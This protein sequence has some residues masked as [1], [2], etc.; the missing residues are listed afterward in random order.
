MSSA[1]V[2]VAGTE[3]AR[4][5]AA[6]GVEVRTLHGMPELEE[7][8]AVLTSIWGF[9]DGNVPV[10]PELL[11]AFAF[12]GGYV[13]AARAGGQIV[14]VSAGFLGRHPGDRDLHLHSHISGVLP[15]WQ[16]RS[17]GLALKQHQRAWA[18]ANGIETI[19]WTF[20]PLVRRNAFFNLVKLGAEIVD[21]KPAFYGE[22]R[23]AINAGDESDRAVVRWT[24]ASSAAVSAAGGFLDRDQPR[25]AV[26]LRA[27]GD[28]QPVAGDAADPVLR[29]WIPDDAVSLRHH[30]PAGGRAWRLALRDTFGAA[31]TDGYQA[32]AMTR[33]GWYTL[34]RATP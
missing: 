31:I 26:I 13:S 2:D 18:L 34:V 20:D 15:P 16:G 7:A 29:A 3:A 1:T 11:R 5:A 17:V 9:G 12:A 22:M 27:D 21:F 33:D 14:G 32:T 28:G 19:E 6:A 23:D 10:S 30:D 8:V 24:L 25:G 4:V